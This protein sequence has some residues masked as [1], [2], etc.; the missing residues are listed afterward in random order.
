VEN[1]KVRLRVTLTYEYDAKPEYYCKPE[2]LKDM[3]PEK[4][5]AIDQDNLQNPWTLA[6]LMANTPENFKLTVEPV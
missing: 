5:A 3:T 1:K 4:M 2:D 6:E